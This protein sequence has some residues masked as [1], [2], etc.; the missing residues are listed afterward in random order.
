MENNETHE[1]WRPLTSTLRQKETKKRAKRE[2]MP[3]LLVHTETITTIVIEGGGV[4]GAK[5]RSGRVVG[6]SPPPLFSRL[7][8]WLAFDSCWIFFPLN[9]CVCVSVCVCVCVGCMAV[10]LLCLAAGLL[11]S[12]S[13]HFPVCFFLVVG[14]CAVWSIHRYFRAKGAKQTDRRV[15]RDAFFF[16]VCGE[17]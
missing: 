12:K 14:M 15:R 3:S 1:K 11:T 9:V 17:A 7:D 13:N 16:F 6:L 8:L 2:A 4:G 5:T 10:L